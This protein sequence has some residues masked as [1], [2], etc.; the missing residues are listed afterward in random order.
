MHVWILVGF[1]PPEL[2]LDFRVVDDRSFYCWK[3]R[4]VEVRHAQGGV[5]FYLVDVGQ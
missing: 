3:Q 1:F 4:D 5:A 2:G